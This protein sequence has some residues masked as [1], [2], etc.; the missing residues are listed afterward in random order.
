MLLFLTLFSVCCNTYN[1]NLSSELHTCQRVIINGVAN[2]NI[3][4]K[5]N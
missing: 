5:Y 3:T 4:M 1:F 2:D